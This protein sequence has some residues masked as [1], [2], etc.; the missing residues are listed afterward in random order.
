MDHKTL[1][2]PE[3]LAPAGNMERL[4]TALF[5]GADAVYLGGKELNLRAKSMG[6]DWPE[7]DLAIKLA[8]K[9]NTKIYYCLNIFPRQ[10]DLAKVKEYLHKLAEHAPDGLIIADPGVIRMAQEISPLIPVHLSTQANTT[11]S[12]AV[13]FWQSLGV[14]RINLARELN[15]RQIKKIRHRCPG[16]ELECFVHGAQCMAWSGRCLLSDYLNNQG[17]NMGRCTHPCRFEYRPLYMALEEKKRPGQPLWEVFEESKYSVILASDDLCLIK[18]LPWFK[19]KQINALKL[20]GR[21]KTIAYLAHVVDV[22]KTALKDLS[23]GRFRPWLY[24]QELSHAASRPLCSGFFLPGRKK[25]YSV[26]HF[27]RQTV[28]GRIEQKQGA[29][30]WLLTVRN[31]FETGDKCILLL[32]GLIRP[33]LNGS[34]FA[35]EDAK[36]MKLSTV[37]PGQ[38]VYLRSAVPALKEGMLL[39]KE[40]V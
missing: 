39:R 4:Q 15:L 9:Q 8:H 37:H 22:Y 10:A 13:K 2:T 23:K 14:T 33:P 17:A 35:L 6:F 25:F 21:I 40:S 32:P 30:K 20:E 18:Y 36:G 12:S 19:K 16:V 26:D 31:Q 28:W 7:L 11:N 24:L 3:L 29:D 5:Y 1:K 34:A 27:P 38:R